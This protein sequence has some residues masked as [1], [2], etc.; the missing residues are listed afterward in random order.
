MSSNREPAMMSGNRTWSRGLRS[1]V[2]NFPCKGPFCSSLW[3][4]TIHLVIKLLTR[5]H[6]LDRYEQQVASERCWVMNF[7]IAKV[8]A[9][10]PRLQLKSDMQL[11]C[12]HCMAN[13]MAACT[14]ST[15]RK[16]LG[17]CS[18]QLHLLC[19]SFFA[20]VLMQKSCR[21]PVHPLAG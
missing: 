13:T 11:Q 10:Q 21:P 5:A 15:W 7:V 1:S 14:H 12:L 8:A 20:Q 4:Y 18:C 6:G 2:V 3:L 19:C 16:G 17:M 9:V